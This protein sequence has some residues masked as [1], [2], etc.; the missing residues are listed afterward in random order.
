MYI[1]TKGKERKTFMTFHNQAGRIK[2]FRNKVCSNVSTQP[3]VN[4]PHHQCFKLLTPQ[5][6]NSTKQ[7]YKIQITKGNNCQKDKC[8]ATWN[9][10]VGAVYHTFLVFNISLG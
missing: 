3:N 6:V 2:F 5:N 7:G 9:R 10:V 1:Y 4:T 8:Q